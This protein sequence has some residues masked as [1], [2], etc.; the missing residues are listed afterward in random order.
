MTTDTTTADILAFVPQRPTVPEAAG[1]TRRRYRT[2]WISDVHL[3]TRG[4]NADMLIDFLDHVDSDQL[5]LVGDI[6]DGWRLKKR[7]YWPASHNDVVWRLMKRAKRG[8][9]VTYIPGNHD[10]VF[11]QF[12]GMD[13]GGVKIRRKAIH[14][15][16]DGRR[17]LVLHGD[18]FDAITLA[19]RWVAFIGD[20][21]Y[22]ALM[23]VNQWLN[24]A[25][26]W[27]GLPYW[28]LSKHAKA[29]VKNAVAFISH[30]EE[31]VAHAA[32]SRGVDGVVCGHI[33]TAEIRDIQGVAYYNDG[34]W[35]EGCTALVEHFDGRMELLHWADEIAARNAPASSDSVT[36]A[37]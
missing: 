6:I 24:V 11:R 23:V 21:A 19:H 28:S 33:H 12:A 3:G 31:V 5:Y 36:R 14:T 2:I 20:S 13:F 35:V 1:V 15:T 8:T 18:E 10:E 32:R 16:A 29:K 25:R 4:C 37:A 34:D 17:L 30:F 22:T 27:L 7:F 9:R 26:R